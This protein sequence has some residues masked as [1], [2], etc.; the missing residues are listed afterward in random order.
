LQCIPEKTVAGSHLGQLGASVEH[1]FSW[2]GRVVIERATIFLLP[3]QRH[4]L[5]H[6]LHA[7]LH[8]VEVNLVLAGRCAGRLR[9]C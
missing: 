6:V 8:I 7:Q 5:L 1:F 3:H 4:Q 2:A 9:L